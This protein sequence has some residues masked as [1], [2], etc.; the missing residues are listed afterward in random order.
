MAPRTVPNGFFGWTWSAVLAGVFASLVVQILLTMLGFGIGLLA[1]DV[2]TA[3]SA[4]AG[5]GWAAFVWWA[6]SAS[7]PPSSAAQLR[8]PIRP[9]R[10]AWGVWGMP[11][12][13]GQWQR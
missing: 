5:A 8:Q 11:W 12:P 2:P 4:P 1:I 10:P 6:V 3:Q 13:P 9:I 7:S